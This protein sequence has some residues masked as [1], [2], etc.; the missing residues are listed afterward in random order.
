MSSIVKIV[1]EV[2]GLATMILGDKLLA[3]WVA[4]YS[5]WLRTKTSN[6]FQ[7]RVNNLCV[8]YESDWE[9]INKP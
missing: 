2:L 4:A 8:E 1:A 7:E 6:E 3:K 9:N 5:I